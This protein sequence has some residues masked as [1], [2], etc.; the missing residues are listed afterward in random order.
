MPNKSFQ[1]EMELT[2]NQSLVIKNLNGHI[3]LIAC[4]G[5]TLHI[6]AKI[7][8]DNQS[9]VDGTDVVVEETSDQVTI[10]VEPAGT[11]KLWGWKS[12]GESAQVDFLIKAPQW[13]PLRA[14]NLNG[15]IRSVGFNHLGE[16][17]SMNGELE[18]KGC[19]GKPTLKAMNGRIVARSCSFAGLE[20]KTMNG[21]LTVETTINQN[22]SYRLKSMQGEIEFLIP[23]GSN[24]FI[25]AKSMR[26]EIDC[27]LPLK[28][29]RR[30]GA[31]L[32][33]ALG[34]GGAKVELKSMSGKIT[35]TEF[36]GT[37]HLEPEE[38]LIAK[39]LKEG[40]ITQ[41]EASKLKETI[42]GREGSCS[43]Q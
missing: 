17:K 37:D 43:P 20:A 27:Q 39:M 7:G 31:K 24:A 41:D 15:S 22:G 32:S 40:R 29:L 3:E 13:V 8:S 35:I 36:G 4:Q 2:D 42:Y 18:A 19:S 5:N 30:S 26:G 1:R 23:R 9:A 6:E 38:E 10:R 25:E 14:K 12:G 28:G 11:R 21:P 16:L 33:G 34:E